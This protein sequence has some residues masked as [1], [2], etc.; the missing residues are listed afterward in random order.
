[1]AA[2]LYNL[3]VKNTFLEVDEDDARS[4]LSLDEEPK[5][6]VTDPTPSITRLLDIDEPDK[7]NRQQFFDNTSTYSTEYSE[8]LDEST[9]EDSSTS[10]EHDLK[11]SVCLHPE[12]ELDLAYCANRM[13]RQPDVEHSSKRKVHS[14][15][16]DALLGHCVFG[17]SGV[18]ER[19]PVVRLVAKEKVHEPDA[20]VKVKVARRRKRDSLI[21]IAA[22]K[23]RLELTQT[24]ELS[25]QQRSHQPVANALPSQRT[26]GDASESKSPANVCHECG[27]KSQAEFKFC[28][29][30]GAAVSLHSNR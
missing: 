11:L 17:D 12:G 16:T 6:Q 23:Q 9:T 18:S 28:R 26:R 22:R 5:R 3:V 25:Q 10:S 14:I 21:D 1:M 13:D 29:F 27:K 8:T 15:P 24:A 7:D 4:D 20:I 19:R 30:C 2:K